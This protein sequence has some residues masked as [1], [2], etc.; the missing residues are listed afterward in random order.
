MLGSSGGAS[1]EHH[2]AHTIDRRA[3]KSFGLGPT[4]EQLKCILSG[5]AAPHALPSRRAFGGGTRC[6]FCGMPPS[7]IRRRWQSAVVAGRGGVSG[8]I[9][10]RE[11]NGLTGR[12]R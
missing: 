3:L 8:V 12:K 11:G 9:K 1:C 10:R 7:S 4:C 6:H 5:V 2:A